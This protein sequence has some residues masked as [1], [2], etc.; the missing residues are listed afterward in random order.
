MECRTGAVYVWLMADNTTCDALVDISA[1][2]RRII[3]FTSVMTNI[4]LLPPSFV[5]ILNT[6]LSL[7]QNHHDK[8]FDNSLI[9]QK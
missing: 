9:L 8:K 6:H 1:V 2:F 7:I 4:S 5:T 3:L